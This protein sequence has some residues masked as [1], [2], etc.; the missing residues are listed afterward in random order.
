MTDNK[1]KKPPRPT[2]PK[3]PPPRAPQTGVNKKKLVQEAEKKLQGAEPVSD[4]EK[5]DLLGN[6]RN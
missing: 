5:D 6:F 3:T 1:D 4:E 2:L